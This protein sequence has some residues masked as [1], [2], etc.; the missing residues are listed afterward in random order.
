MK[1]NVVFLLQMYAEAKEVKK[2]RNRNAF[3]VPVSDDVMKMVRANFTREIEFYEFC[4]QRL[5]KQYLDLN[6]KSLN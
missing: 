5:E 6:L 2:F 3:K 1:V 4:K